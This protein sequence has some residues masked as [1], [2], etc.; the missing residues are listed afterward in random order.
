MNFHSLDFMTP[1]EVRKSAE[2][3]RAVAATLEPLH[4][5]GALRFPIAVKAVA[6]SHG[7]RTAAEVAIECAVAGRLD[8]IASVN[9]DDAAAYVAYLLKVRRSVE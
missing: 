2:R 8:K 5:V 3:G 1:A 7:S 4:A 9:H 6:Q